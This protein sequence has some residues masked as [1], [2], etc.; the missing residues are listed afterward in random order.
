MPLPT[1]TRNWLK[2]R[3]DDRTDPGIEAGRVF[4]SNDDAELAAKRPD[5]ALH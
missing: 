3:N 1:L 2:T 4:S 5:P